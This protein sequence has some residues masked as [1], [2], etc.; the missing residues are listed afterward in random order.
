MNPFEAYFSHRSIC[1]I[2]EPDFLCHQGWR[3]ER[4]G[5]RAWIETQ[6]R[7]PAVPPAPATPPEKPEDP[8]PENGPGG[9]F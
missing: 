4:A 6:K 8:D 9:R 1:L 7:H 2:C 3:L 5:L